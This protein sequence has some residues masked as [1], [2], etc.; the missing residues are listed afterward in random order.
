MSDLRITEEL[1]SLFSKEPMA[2]IVW[3]DIMLK[4]SKDDYLL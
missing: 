2:L 3:A 4:I 1:I